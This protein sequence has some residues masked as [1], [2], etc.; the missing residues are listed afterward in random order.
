M[1]PFLAFLPFVVASA[2]TPAVTLKSSD[3]V[4]VVGT[5][6]GEVQQSVAPASKAKVAWSI[7][8][9]E[10]DENPR[11]MIYLMVG[12]KK[13]KLMVVA[14]HPDPAMK[15]SEADWAPKGALLVLYAWWAGGGDQLYV[16][17][18]GTSYKVYHRPLDE[19]SVTGKFR[20]IKT[21]KG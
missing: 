2:S 19:G 15:V 6:R 18:K 11:A 8:Q 3:P 20:V 14:G 5:T 21:I 10:S 7:A 17:K 16:L 9:V 12:K 1:L 13:T 4:S